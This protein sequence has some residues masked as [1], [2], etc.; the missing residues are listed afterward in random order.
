MTRVA[1]W[2]KLEDELFVVRDLVGES[3]CMAARSTAELHWSSS[4]KSAS[5]VCSLPSLKPVHIVFC[6]LGGKQ[7]EKPSERA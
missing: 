3:K 2:K 5:D 6:S 7:D 1:K 4:A